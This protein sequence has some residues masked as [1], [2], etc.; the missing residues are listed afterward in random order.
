M[1]KYFAYQDNC[2][3]LQIKVKMLIDYQSLNSD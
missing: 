3:T 2:L 1:L